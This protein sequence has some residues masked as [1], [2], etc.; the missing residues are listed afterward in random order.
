MSIYIIFLSYI[1]LKI[2]FLYSKICSLWCTVLC[3]CS[4]GHIFIFWYHC[5]RWTWSLPFRIL[6]LSEHFLFSE[7]FKLLLIWIIIILLVFFI[8]RLGVGLQ[9]T[10]YS[11]LTELADR[12]IRIFVHVHIWNVR[13]F[14]WKETCLEN[15]YQGNLCQPR[16][17]KCSK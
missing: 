12:K 1:N 8:N 11:H 4:F 7:R 17:I 10:K 9:N 13:K 15:V 5:I 16:K 6:W 3:Y 14:Y 2:V